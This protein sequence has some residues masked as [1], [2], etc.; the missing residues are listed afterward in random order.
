MILHI[1][2]VNGTAIT[3]HNRAYDNGEGPD[4]YIF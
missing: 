4:L 1:L 2:V 3:G